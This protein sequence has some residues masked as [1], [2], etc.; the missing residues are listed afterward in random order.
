MQNDQTFTFSRS[1]GFRRLGDVFDAAGYSNEGVAERLG[2][3]DAR[4]FSEQSMPRLL[5]ATEGG[6][7]LDVLIRLFLIGSTL[8]TAAVEKAVRPMK[9]AEWVE[10]GLIE[11]RGQSTAGRLEILP[12]Q[13]MRIAFDQPRRIQTGLAEDYVMGIGSSTLTLANLTVRRRARAALDLGT[14]CGYLAFLAAG[15]SEGVTAVDRNPRAVRLARFNAKLNGLSN[16]ECL[17][18]DLFEP[19]AGRKFE[20]VVSNP[21]FVISPETRYIY[22]DSGMKGDEITRTIVGR[23]PE[24]L[25]EGGFCQ[26]LCNWAHLRGQAW[27]QRLGE[28]FEGLGCDAWVMRSDTLEAEAYA[29]KWIRHTE[30][31]NDDRFERR[32]EQ[33]TDYYRREEIEAVSGGLITMR[34]RSGGV[35]NWFRADDGPEKMLG[36]AGNA[37]ATAFEL[38]DFVEANRDDT[39]LGGKCL[40]VSPDARLRQCFQPG[41]SGWQPTESLLTLERGLAYT[42]TIDPYIATLLAGCNGKRTLEELI[43]EMARSVEQEVAE[44]RPACLEIIRRLV[45]RGFLMAEKIDV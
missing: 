5:Q 14:G 10:A 9:L 43:G 45:E 12:F 23:A 36:P 26:I 2:I 8:E 25:A 33:W 3:G 24:F 4:S 13:G 20:L 16:V 18:G 7:P 19:V 35:A 40:R 29:T 22:R 15:H 17:E 42:G 31:D 34:R 28:W 41:E 37:L 21:P 6:T 27:Q 30:R 32:Y 38:R 39:T 11:V 1:D 44:I